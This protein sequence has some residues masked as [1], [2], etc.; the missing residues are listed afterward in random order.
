VITNPDPDIFQEQLLAWSVRGVFCA[1][2]SFVW[3]VF[4]EFR[5]PIQLAAMLA[6]I[7]TYVVAYAWATA[8][9]VYRERVETSDLGRSFRWAANARAALAP[10]MFFGPD[11]WLGVLS[12]WLIE[13]LA[14]PLGFKAS[15]D[16]KSFGCTYAITLTQGALVSLAMFMLTLVIWIVRPKIMGRLH[17]GFVAVQRTIATLRG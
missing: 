9:P 14:G 4:L 16:A 5:Q 6:G 13:S 8:L 3:A 17:D 2:P 10:L 7:A 1:A 11:A 12:I 15:V